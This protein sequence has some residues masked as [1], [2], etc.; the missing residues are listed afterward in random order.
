MKKKY[1]IAASDYGG[2]A[3]HIERDDEV[4]NAALA[5]GCKDPFPADD[6]QAAMLAVKDG[7]R[8]IEDLPV[9]ETDEDFAYYIDTP[10]NRK[11]LADY[12]ATERNIA[13]AM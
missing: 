4:F 2:G 11:K 3:L 1:V 9:T 13:M 7:I 8:L 10:D 6:A 5:D 12:F